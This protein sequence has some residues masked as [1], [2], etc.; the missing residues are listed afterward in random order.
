M[1]TLRSTLSR[2]CLV[3]STF[4]CGMETAEL[5]RSSQEATPSSCWRAIAFVLLSISVLFS[6]LHR[7]V[8]TALAGRNGILVLRCHA[9]N[10]YV[11]LLNH[12]SV[13]HR[14]V[15]FSRIFNA[16]NMSNGKHIGKMGLLKR[17]FKGSIGD[18]VFG[19]EDGTVSVFGLVFGMALSVTEHDVLLA[20]IAG[21]A[22]GAISM[23]AGAYLDA[24][25]EQQAQS[26]WNSQ[27]AGIN[28]VKM[29]D[30]KALINQLSES[31]VAADD[32][33]ALD[34]LLRHNPR[35]MEVIEEQAQKKQGNFRSSP[36]VQSIWM[37]IAD[38]LASSVPIIPFF[39]FD[40]ERARVWSIVVTSVLLIVLGIGRSRITHTN[41][42]KTVVETVV[43]AYAAAIGGILLI[44]L[45]HMS[46][47]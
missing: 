9:N 33:T 39:F 22:A 12:R 37:L 30:R 5:Q 6:H 36:F 11:Y 45:F 27:N 46:A 10:L 41:T 42:L 40:L 25:S 35:I 43:I 26:R 31:G 1:R 15:S 16:M 44:K 7:N 21:G 47:F 20:G 28:D 19:M 17:S 3:L 29:E 4:N 14:V 24:K 34:G 18:I 2:H 8:G 32:V 23:M 38:I 13:M